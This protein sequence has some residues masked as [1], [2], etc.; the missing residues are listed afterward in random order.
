M[1]LTG[2]VS[3]IEQPFC[4]GIS[5]DMPKKGVENQLEEQKP[6]YKKV[7]LSAVTTMNL[8]L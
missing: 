4:H 8:S 7:W 3:V 2:S 6:V 5:L 1:K